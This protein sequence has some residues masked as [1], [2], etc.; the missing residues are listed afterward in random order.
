MPEISMDK[1]GNNNGSNDPSST[2]GEIDILELAKKVYYLLL[3]ELE[4]DNDRTGK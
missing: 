3:S 1:T 2:Q 4:R